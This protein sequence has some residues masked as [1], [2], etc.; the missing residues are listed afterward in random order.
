MLRLK[1]VSMMNNFQSH[2]FS[3]KPFDVL[4]ALLTAFL[5]V[6]A[7]CGVH[8]TIINVLTIGLFELF[9]IVAYSLIVHRFSAFSILWRSSR[10]VVFCLILWLISVSLSLYFA[11]NQPALLAEQVPAIY[12]SYILFLLHVLFGFCVASF[13][14]ESGMNARRFLLALSMG[15]FLLCL[16]MVFL[17]LQGH[18]GMDRYWVHGL[19][20]AIN[21]RHVGYWVTAASAGA[22]ALLLIE[23]TPWKKLALFIVAVVCAATLIWMGGRTGTFSWLVSVCVLLMMSAYCGV[24]T[25]RRFWLIILALVSAFTLSSLCS[26]YDWNGMTRMISTVSEV[27]SEGHSEGFTEGRTLLWQVAIDAWKTS[28]W[29][30]LGANAF[31]FLP[32]RPHGVHPH[33]FLIQLLLEWGIVG[34]SLFL[35]LFVTACCLP[36][37]QVFKE[38]TITANTLVAGTILISLLVHA[39]TDGIFWYARPLMYISLAL[40]I[41]LVSAQGGKQEEVVSL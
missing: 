26:V 41:Y 39:L 24:L 30:G 16:Y 32:D 4:S 29:F 2:F 20:F 1:V 31:L 8:N 9:F 34:L 3:F 37:V 12:T 23:Q 17:L 19:P 11:V 13:L 25:L 10:W 15:V 27:N 14:L 5:L 38:K 35:L 33:N 36:L 6:M 7:L 18:E 21:I 28:P 40:A 22:F